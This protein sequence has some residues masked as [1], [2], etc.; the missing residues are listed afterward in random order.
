[1]NIEVYKYEKEKETYIFYLA[2]PELNVKTHMTFDR[3]ELL[4]CPGIHQLKIL[5]EARIKDAIYY[6]L[7]SIQDKKIIEFIADHIE[8]EDIFLKMLVVMM[9]PK[10]G[11][12]E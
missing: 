10:L 11:K 6:M 12:I 8:M 4:M 5:F 3:Q 2:I 7:N 9:E 1:M